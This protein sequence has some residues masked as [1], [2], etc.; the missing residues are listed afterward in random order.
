MSVSGQLTGRERSAYELLR[1]AEVLYER[2]EAGRKEPFNLF[3]V[4]RKASDEEH[5]H[6]KFL[7]AL[8]NWE[9]PEDGAEKGAKK[10]LRDFVEQ[11]VAPAVNTAH[12]EAAREEAEGG[13]AESREDRGESHPLLDLEDA[14]PSSTPPAESHEPREADASNGDA[15]RSGPLSAG[16]FSFS[17][18]E[19]ATV[20]R[21]RHHIDLLITNTKGQAIVIENKIWAGDQRRQLDRYF[22]AVKRRG[23]EPTLVYL[24]LDGRPPSEQSRR[25]RVVA[26][27]SYR[28]DL[29]P[30]LRGCQERACDEPALRES[31]AQYLSLIR[32]LCGDAG[33]EFM[34]E[35][36]KLLRE[37][38]DLIL[39]RTLGDAATVAWGDLLF[40]YWERVRQEVEKAIGLPDQSDLRGWIKRFVDRRAGHFHYSWPL[41]SE[42]APAPLALEARRDGGIFWGVICGNREHQE[43]YGRLKDKLSPLGYAHAERWWSGRKF[44]CEGNISRPSERVLAVLDNTQKRNEVVRDLIET[45]KSL[46]KS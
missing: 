31:V 17:L 7:A 16:K 46:R 41:P 28:E 5:L 14:A 12:E 6:S 20:E 32:T 37:G 29:I 26:C 42:W 25:K 3:S 10:N 44:V 21:E 45:W 18:D 19:G 39:A 35:L 11:V 30:W 36:T 15:D 23:L 38:N 22:D 27:L 34:T 43:L 40:D 9:T 4:L 33:R 13:E 2:Y 8:L 24:T 1:Q